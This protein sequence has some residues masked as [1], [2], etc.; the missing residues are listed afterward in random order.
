MFYFSVQNLDMALALVLVLICLFNW[1]ISKHKNNQ[2]INFG[3]A[4]TV[5]ILAFYYQATYL[6]AISIIAVLWGLIYV[7]MWDL[8]N[9]PNKDG[10]VVEA[11]SNIQFLGI[12]IIRIIQSAFSIP[13]IFRIMFFM[14]PFG[15]GI[16]IIPLSFNKEYK[17]R[18]DGSKYKITKMYQTVN[19][20]KYNEENRDRDVWDIYFDLKPKVKDQLRLGLSTL[21]HMENFVKTSKEYTNKYKYDIVVLNDW[22][23]AVSKNDCASIKDIYKYLI[24]YNHKHNIGI[25]EFSL[26]SKE[27]LGTTL[28]PTNETYTKEKRAKL[29]K[30][31]VKNLYNKSWKK[32][33]EKSKMNPNKTF[34]MNFGSETI[35][36]R[37]GVEIKREK[38]EKRY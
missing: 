3:I 20:V 23:R 33:Y 14:I 9:K 28:S 30:I 19:C 36:I 34:K 10:E 18:F 25:H 26:V 38:R 11:T 35:S 4:F 7:N 32:Y 8:V 12:F 15:V 22:N 29:E 31:R 13:G 17:D 2:L 6:I 37:N 5:A 24:E 1:F 16:F 21:E 27:E